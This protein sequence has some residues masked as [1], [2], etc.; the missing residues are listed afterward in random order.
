MLFEKLVEQHR[1]HRVVAH[2]VGLS[3]FIAHDQIR[4]HFFNLLSYKS[5]LRCARGVDRLPVMEGNGV[6]C[7]ERFTGFLHRLDV[8]LEPGG[9]RHCAELAICIHVNR[10]AIRRRLTTNASD[11]CAG[12]ICIADADGVAFASHT[13][14]ADVNIPVAR[15]EKPTAPQGDV[16]A[17]GGVAIQRLNS[18]GRII[19]AGGVVIERLN[20]MGRVA[21]AD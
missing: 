21:V 11:K 19:V 4:I 9:R 13:I 15:G 2:G 3:F 6:Q 5:E 16:V 8:I 18:I 20:T 14:V 12:L 1:V 17:A 10:N 7:Q